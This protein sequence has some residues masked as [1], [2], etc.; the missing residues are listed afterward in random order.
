MFCCLKAFCLVTPKIVRGKQKKKK[1]NQVNV[2]VY[3][4]FV[5]MTLC[6]RFAVPKY[7]FK[8]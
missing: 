2:A 3:L 4:I 6:V 5:I 1:K 7:G 8:E